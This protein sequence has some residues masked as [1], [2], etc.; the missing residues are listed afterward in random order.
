MSR[1][2]HNKIHLLELGNYPLVHSLRRQSP[3]VRPKLSLHLS[4]TAVQNGS[5][6]TPDGLSRT[7]WRETRYSHTVEELTVG[8]ITFALRH[9]A[10]QFV[11]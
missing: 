9:Q 6:P 10:I 5:G 2:Q 7:D 4:S 8:F 3:P 1:H 11:N